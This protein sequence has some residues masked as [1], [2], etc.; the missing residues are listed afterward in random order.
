MK[1]K[2]K[3]HK[4]ILKRFKV[5]GTGK[6]VRRRSGKGHL[7]SNKPGQRLIRLRG[8]T[9]VDGGLMRK[10]LRA[11]GLPAPKHLQMKIH[12]AEQGG[13]CEEGGC[14]CEKGGCSKN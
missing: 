9:T 13:C 12:N 8:K 7:L 10:Q 6:I 3:S 11:L 4:G 2:Q 1:T 5:T 14:G